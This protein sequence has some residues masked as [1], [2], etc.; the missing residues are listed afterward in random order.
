M[1]A[2][3]IANANRSGVV[4]NLLIEQ[5]M[6]ARERV[7][8]TFVVS[9]ARHKTSSNS[10]PAKICLPIKIYQQVKA[11]ILHCRPASEE[12]EVFLS[13]TGRPLESSQVAK[14]IQSAWTKGGL[15]TSFTCTIMRKSA[16]TQIH[17]NVPAMKEPL[18][19]LMAH[20]PTTATK[21]YR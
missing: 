7:A 21:S 10:G 16:V 9:V 2:I 20:L 6:N 12:Q 19:D 4:A 3:C 8:G 14:A 17:E 13:W 5:V 11:F 15:A 1:L 18:S